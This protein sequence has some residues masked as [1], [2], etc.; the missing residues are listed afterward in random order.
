[1]ENLNLFLLLVESSLIFNKRLVV[2]VIIGWRA[3]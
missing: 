1:M 3:Y 2:N